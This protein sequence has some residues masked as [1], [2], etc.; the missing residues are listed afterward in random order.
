MSFHQT[1]K[2]HGM[3][4]NMKMSTTY[5]MRNTRGRCVIGLGL[6]GGGGGNKPFLDVEN[7]L[8]DMRTLF[9]NW[10]YGTCG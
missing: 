7:N 3:E 4:S 8:Y 9:F 1:I 5:T 6:E 2:D 10:I